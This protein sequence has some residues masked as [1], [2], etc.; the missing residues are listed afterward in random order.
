MQKFLGKILILIGSIGV[1]IV[2]LVE[3][4]YLIYALS[5]GHFLSL[6]EISNKNGWYITIIIVLMLIYFIV[7]SIFSLHQ[8]S[9]GRSSKK[10]FY[11]SIFIILCLVAKNAFFYI[12]IKDNVIDND[13]GYYLSINV[14]YFV[15]LAIQCIGSLLNYHK[16]K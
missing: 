10:T 12:T 8:I 13:Y 14:S 6:V 4:I 2:N 3:I 11:L 16:N 1:L 15:F 5:N 9:L 7:E